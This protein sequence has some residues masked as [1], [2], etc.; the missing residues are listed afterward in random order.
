MKKF[1]KKFVKG[2][3][4]MFHHFHDNDKNLKSQGSISNFDLL[5]I[6]KYIGV[7]NIFTPLEFQKKI[8]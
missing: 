7:K 8:Y 6:I 1:S 5:K 3:G 2:T 4:V